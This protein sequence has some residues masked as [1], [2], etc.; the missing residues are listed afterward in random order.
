MPKS[1]SFPPGR[2]IRLKTVFSFF[3]SVMTCSPVSSATSISQESQLALGYSLPHFLI[4]FFQKR[5][6][7]FLIHIPAQIMS[8]WK[9]SSW[10]TLRSDQR[11]AIKDTLSVSITEGV[12][13]MVS[14]QLFLLLIYRGELATWPS[15]EQRAFSAAKAD[16]YGNF[17][18]CWN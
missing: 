3:F 16:F 12:T 2:D 9:H 18:S 6:F 13:W 4:F 7:F 1:M 15:T 17:Q 5:G 8:P 10:Q 11:P 14:C